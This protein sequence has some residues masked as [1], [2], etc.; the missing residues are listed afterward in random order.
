M[1]YHIVN[2][3]DTGFHCPASQVTRVSHYDI[4]CKTQIVK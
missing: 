2:A 3:I 1:H 4:R